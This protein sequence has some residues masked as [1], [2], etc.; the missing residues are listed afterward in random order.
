MVSRRIKRARPKQYQKLFPMMIKDWRN[1]WGYDFPF[2]FVQ[3]A[4]FKYDGESKDKLAELRDAQR[5]TLKL[6]ILEW[7]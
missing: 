5:L 7:L 1:R 3:L 2:Y 6:L 4:P